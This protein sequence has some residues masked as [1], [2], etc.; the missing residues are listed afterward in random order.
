MIYRV[1][2]ILDK[3]VKQKRTEET[4]YIYNF[5]KRTDIIGLSICRKVGRDTMLLCRVNTRYSH[6]LILR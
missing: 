5:E 2:F 6:T 4:K 3:F 1:C